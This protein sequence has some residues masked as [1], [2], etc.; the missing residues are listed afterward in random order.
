MCFFSTRVFHFNAVHG[1]ILEHHGTLIPYDFTPLGGRTHI[2]FDVPPRGGRTH[3]GSNTHWV[4]H[5]SLATAIP[6]LSKP[7][8]LTIRENHLPYYSPSSCRPPTSDSFH[9]TTKTTMTDETNDALVIAQKDDIIAQ[10]NDII[11]QQNV[12]IEKLAAQVK[13]EREE[14]EDGD[15]T[16]YIANQNAIIENLTAQVA[17][18]ARIT[19]L[20]NDVIEHLRN[21]LKDAREEVRRM[22]TVLDD[23]H[24]NAED[25]YEKQMKMFQRMIDLHGLTE[26]AEQSRRSQ[27]EQVDAELVQLVAHIA[28]FKIAT[29]MV[30]QNIANLL[31]LREQ[32]EEEILELL[33]AHVAHYE[34]ADQET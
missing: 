22:Q 23:E 14:R 7:R 19:A 32:G 21:E 24:T 15:E 4:E 20:Q 31:Q 12:I 5:T 34:G 16:N 10:L 9:A 33:Q 13:S 3:I 18:D 26:R 8:A 2:A 27:R 11:A 30:E 1:M 28:E 17:G 25:E 29:N 6:P